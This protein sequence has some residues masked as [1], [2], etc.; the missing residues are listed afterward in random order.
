M[1]AYYTQK[2]PANGGG[3]TV[4]Y[5]GNRG[6]IVLENQVAVTVAA[7]DNANDDIGFF[8]APAGFVVVGGSISAGDMDSTTTLTLDFGDAS[9][10]DRFFA[11][12][13]VGQ[14]GTYSAALAATG[15]MY[16]FTARTECRLY[17]NTATGGTP[18]AATVKVALIGF[19]DPDYNTTAQA[20]STT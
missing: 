6:M 12:S 15:H 9:D 14:A 7:S 16:K 20:V 19:V 8:Y 2:A 1:A 18:A 10:E 5:G 17:V 11:V 4:G 3:P 13:A